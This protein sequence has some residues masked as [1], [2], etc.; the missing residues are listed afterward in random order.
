VPNGLLGS[1]ERE[2]CFVDEYL[3][4]QLVAMLTGMARTL[5]DQD[6]GVLASIVDALVAEADHRRARGYV[7][8]DDASPE[9]LER[10]VERA[11][12]LKKRFEALLYLRRESTPIEEH[13]RPWVTA[14][15]AA[16]A[17]AIAFT[18]QLWFGTGRSAVGQ[19]L[20]WGFV[21]V[22]MLVAVTYGTKERLQIAGV[23]WLSR[24]LG[25][26]YARRSTRFFTSPRTL[27]LSAR[28]SF[29]EESFERADADARTT[30]AMVR[31]RFVHEGRVRPAA[32]SGQLRLIFRY[33]L[34]PLFPRLHDPV[35]I[36][37]IV[38]RDARRVRF[39]D[40]PRRYRLS[41]GV[42]LGAGGIERTLSAAIVMDKFGLYG[43]DRG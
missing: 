16:T 42:T 1:L 25:R 21:I 38:D 32:A 27:V 20:G 7:S 43:I 35:K 23:Q 6:P 11:R 26:L 33:D 3:S 40:A 2:R 29:A 18:L 30:V 19:Q 9:A 28:E 8:I 37:G 22:L 15:S 31:L 10:L 17:G 39:V 34:S 24:S 4:T 12:V 13:I 41:L 5:G 36:V 14:M